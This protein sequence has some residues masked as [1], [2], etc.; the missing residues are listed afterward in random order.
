MGNETDGLQ[1]LSW[2]LVS[3]NTLFR[4]WFLTGLSIIGK[5]KNIFFFDLEVIIV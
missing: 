3:F 1:F 5:V 2:F 4:Q